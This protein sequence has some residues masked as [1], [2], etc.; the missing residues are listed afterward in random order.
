MKRERSELVAHE[1]RVSVLQAT[2]PCV[3]DDPAPFD[4]LIASI[5]LDGRAG[6]AQGR[7][8]PVCQPGVRQVDVIRVPL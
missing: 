1:E 3:L 2:V 8:D 7:P 4:A 5:K 6:E